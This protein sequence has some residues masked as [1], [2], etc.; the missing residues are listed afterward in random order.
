V[1]NNSSQLAADVRLS[2]DFDEKV[3]RLERMEPAFEQRRDRIH[4][5]NLRPGERKTVAFYFD[6]QVC[7]RSFINATAGWE[8]ALGE[9]HSASM[10]TRAAEV[11]CPAFSTVGQANTAMLRR[12][13]QEE[14]A[15]RDSKYFR[16]GAA[17]S[18]HEVF[19]AC[20]AAVLAQD[21]RLVKQFEVERP[22]RAE[23]WFYGETKVQSSP[24]VIWT[25][26]FGQEKVAQFSVA[27]NAQASI[28][29]LLAE[30]GRRLQESKP[31]GK[32]GHFYRTLATRLLRD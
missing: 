1:D 20:K 19:E 4:L 28:T 11:V 14:L 5:G 32:P 31:G 10:R 21:V 25:S 6:P 18:P 24:M 29:G 22:Y 23:A 3:L 8:D 27:S 30:L 17:A 13:L 16:M 12:L 2:L 26:V 15:F 7:T 9:F